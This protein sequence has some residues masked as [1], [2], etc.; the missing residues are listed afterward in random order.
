MMERFFSKRLFFSV[1]NSHTLLTGVY[2]L[3]SRAPGAGG[4]GV[5]RPSGSIVVV[6]ASIGVGVIVGAIATRQS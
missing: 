2:L 4:R 5:G 1:L 3:L 6:A